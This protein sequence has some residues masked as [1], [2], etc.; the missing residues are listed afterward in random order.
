MEG[1]GIAWQ[2]CY[3]CKARGWV[4]PWKQLLWWW[5]QTAAFSWLMRKFHR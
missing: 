3:F 5:W 2:S 1:L 4:L